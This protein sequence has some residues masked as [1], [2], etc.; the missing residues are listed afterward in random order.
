M[1]NEGTSFPIKAGHGCIGCSED[2]FWDKARS[3][4]A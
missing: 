1:W 2:G 4:T 3:T